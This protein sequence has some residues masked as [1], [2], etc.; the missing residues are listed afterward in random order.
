MK[1]AVEDISPVKKKIRIEV[2]PDA[3]TAEMNK[4][5]ADIAKKAK[6]PGFRPGKAPKAIVEKHYA[7]E[8]RSDV[9]NRLITDSYFRAVHEQKISPVDMPEIGDVSM[10]RG[11]PLS[12]SATVEVRPDIRLGTYGG[13]EVKEQNLTV[14]DEEVA[15]TIDRLREMYAQLEVVEGRPVQKEDTLVIDFQ[16]FHEG[17]AIDGA[18][19]SDYMLTLGKGSLIPGFEDQLEGM[20]KGE[21]REIKVT[22]PGDYSNAELAGKDAQFTVTLQEIKR[23]VVPELNDEFAKDIGDHKSVEDLRARIKE[24]IEVRKRNEQAS[25][26]REELLSKLI[27]AHS[28]DVPP[29]MVEREL[30]SMFRQ[31]A[32]RLARQGADVKSLDAAAF[33][34]QHRALAEGRVKGVLI[35]DAVA[36]RENVAVGDEEL[37]AELAVIARKSG[38]P[39]EAV[40]KYY[41]SLDGG[42]DNLRSS[43]IQE[44]ALGLLLSRAKKVYN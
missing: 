7:E 28:F 26:Q 16:G 25:A 22:F 14:T 11:E 43:L 31:H 33:R 8:V 21:T 1:V 35:L 23:A 3:V 38:Q 4:A 5:I 24:D 30:Q 19:A 20:S 18:K 6:I 17:K 2:S 36:E 27:E 34:D 42:M 40:R 29:G 15:Q 37:S 32:T 13:V 9:V 44:K 41:D 12:F 39:V 10:N